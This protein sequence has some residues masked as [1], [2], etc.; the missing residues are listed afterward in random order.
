MIKDNSDMLSDFL[1][2]SFNTSLKSTKFSHYLKIANA[3]P[4]HR[5]GKTDHKRN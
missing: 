1:C 5:K 2:T 3:T 4:L